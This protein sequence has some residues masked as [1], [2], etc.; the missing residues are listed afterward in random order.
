MELRSWKSN[1]LLNIIPCKVPYYAFI[2][3]EDLLNHY[4]SVLQTLQERFGLERRNM[5]R[6]IPVIK[7]KGEY[8]EIFQPRKNQISEPWKKY[9]WD[10]LNLDQE[11]TMGYYPEPILLNAYS[12]VE[13]LSE[14][15][16]DE[17]FCSFAKEMSDH[18][19]DWIQTIMK[20]F[21]PYSHDS[22]ALPDKALTHVSEAILWF[23][24]PIDTIPFPT[25]PD[26]TSCKGRTT[27]L[28]KLQAVLMSVVADLVSYEGECNG[29]LFQDIV[30]NKLM[31]SLQTSLGSHE[32]EIHTEQAFSEWRPD[33]LSLACLR[34]DPNALTYILSLDQ[35]LE[36]TTE[37]EHAMMRMPLWTIGVDLSFDKKGEIRGPIPILTDWGLT[38]D[39][40]L[41]N[42]I[43][44]K[45]NQLLD[46]IVQ[47]YYRHRSVHCLKEG[48][49][50]FINNRQAV[51][52][53]SGFEP[54]Y[55]GKDRFLVRCFGT[56]D[57]ERSNRVRNGRMILKHYS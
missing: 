57:L 41:M 5:E 52:G 19:P 3:Y 16:D 49:I 11:A 22:E 18:L 30:P 1:Y 4:E 36:N 21:V 31:Q 29:Q 26:N 45:A 35:I 56:L 6:W 8:D 43:N 2:R 50:L 42:G 20:Q 53:R 24:V 23:S 14:E 27:L 10:R 13:P 12:W 47:I 51:H 40:D 9:I 25:P 44:E 37:A 39:Q 15:M 32:L 33:I 34:S 55:D 28:A 54:K 17:T 7:Y 38:F 48:D 46:K